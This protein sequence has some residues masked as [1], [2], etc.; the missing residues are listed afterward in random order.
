MSKTDMDKL[1]KA[2]ELEAQIRQ[3]KYFIATLDIHDPV[4]NKRYIKGHIT[5]KT[6]CTS[7][8][9]IFG[10]RH[11]GCGHHEQVINVPASLVEIVVKQAKELLLVK[12]KEFKNL[13][14]NENE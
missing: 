2:N 11:F 9:S 13:F 12:E 4:K 1:K 10:Y 6:K 14:N 5:K 7:E 3:I 8:Y